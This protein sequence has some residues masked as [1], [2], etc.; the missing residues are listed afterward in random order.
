MRFLCFIAYHLPF[1]IIY[2]DGLPYMI[3]YY[4]FGRDGE[5]TSAGLLARTP[6]NVFLHH[7]VASD[8]SELHNHP[9]PCFSVILAGGY[10]EER[11]GSTHSGWNNVRWVSPG[12]LNVIGTEVFHRLIVPR[13]GSWSLFFS[14]RKVQKWGFTSASGTFRVASGRTNG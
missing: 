6:F 14:G 10:A 1:R 4:L 9:Y 3:R 7:L 5:Q 8:G 13:E 12:Q 11:A 2:R